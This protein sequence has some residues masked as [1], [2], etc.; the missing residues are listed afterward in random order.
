MQHDTKALMKRN[1]AAV[2]S[3]VQ[4]EEKMI[5]VSCCE[6]KVRANSC[7]KHQEPETTDMNPVTKQSYASQQV[8][9]LI[10]LSSRFVKNFA[11]STQII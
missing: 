9:T 10:R 7:H 5:K 3:D 2:V 6:E 8:T 4:L 11:L 1:A